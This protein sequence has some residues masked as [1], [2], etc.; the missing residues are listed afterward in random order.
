[1]VY[2]AQND[3]YISVF[4]GPQ[5]NVGPGYV[6]GAHNSCAQ[7][8]YTLKRGLETRVINFQ[9]SGVPRGTYGNKTYPGSYTHKSWLAKNF[10]DQV[11]PGQLSC[12]GYRTGASAVA[13]NCTLNWQDWVYPNNDSDATRKISMKTK[14]WNQTGT[15]FW[16]ITTHEFIQ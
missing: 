6:N 8:Q 11:G 2:G 9:V 10:E 4:T 7:I 16:S 14:S 5:V 1:M 3:N 12:C 15:I 13:S